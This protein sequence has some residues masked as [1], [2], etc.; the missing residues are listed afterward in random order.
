MNLLEEVERMIHSIK[1]WLVPLHPSP[2]ERGR[3]HGFAVTSGG[4]EVEKAHA[5]EENGE[6]KVDGR[7]SRSE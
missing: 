5:Q 2:K 6:I 1:H 4:G 3:C 7:S